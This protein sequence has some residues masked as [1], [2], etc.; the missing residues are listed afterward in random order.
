MTFGIIGFMFSIN[1]LELVACKI[2]DI[3]INIASVERL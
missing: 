2:F 1:E 3:Y